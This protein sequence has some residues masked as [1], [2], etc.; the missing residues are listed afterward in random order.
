MQTVTSFFTSLKLLN[1]SDQSRAA[2]VIVYRK[3]GV[4][5]GIA[6]PMTLPPRQAFQRDDNQIFPLGSSVGGLIVGSI[7]V[8]VDGPAILGDVV[9]GDPNRINFSATIPLQQTLYTKTVFSQVTNRPV[10][11]LDLA[12]DMF[13]EIAVF[14][15]NDEAVQVVLRVFS[16]EGLGRGEK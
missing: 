8:Q 7:E 1:I 9:F 15:P 11:Q 2:T 10:D 4:I 12:A 5:V 14:N 13:S 3:D 6:D 16:A